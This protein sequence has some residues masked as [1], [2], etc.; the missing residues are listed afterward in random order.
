MQFTD[1]TNAIPSV[2]EVFESSFKRPT[3]AKAGAAMVVVVSAKGGCALITGIW[4]D[5]PLLSPRV[6]AK[7]DGNALLWD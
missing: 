6:L 7:T 1:R 2:L 3:Y 5:G 4:S